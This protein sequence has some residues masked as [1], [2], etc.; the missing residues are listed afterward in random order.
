[1]LVP[2]RKICKTPNDVVALIDRLFRDIT[3]KKS[4][5][6]FRVAAEMRRGVGAALVEALVIQPKFAGIGVDLAKLA[7]F[8][9]GK[10]YR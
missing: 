9:K 4:L 1:L 3:A 8:F 2:L 10:R 7:R 5:D 6:E